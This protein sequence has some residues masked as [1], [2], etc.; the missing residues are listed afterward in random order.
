MHL[1]A[2]KLLPPALNIAAQFVCHRGG[3]LV[4]MPCLWRAGL[5]MKMHAGAL[6]NMAD[7]V[8]HS[9]TVR[10][11]MCSLVCLGQT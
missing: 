9:C 2:V 7:S 8:L 10:N 6:T 4:G 3:W 1:V 5:L 11:N